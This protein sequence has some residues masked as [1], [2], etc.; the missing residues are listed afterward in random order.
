MKQKE[1]L[2]YIG[3]YVATIIGVGLFVGFVT[4]FCCWATD[5]SIGGWLYCVTALFCVVS[6]YSL[7][8]CYAKKSWNMNSSLWIIAMLAFVFFGY[9]AIRR[10]GADGRFQGDY[11]L[12]QRAFDDDNGRYGLANKYATEILWCEYGEIYKVV[13]KKDGNEVFVGVEYFDD[14]YSIEFF[15]KNGN[16]LNGIGMNHQIPAKDNIELFIGAIIETYT[17]DSKLE[18]INSGLKKETTNTEAEKA[19]VPIDSLAE[20]AKHIDEYDDIGYFN[21]GLASAKKNNKYGLINKLGGI[22]VECQYDEIE[23]VGEGLL[24][25]KQNDKYS[26]ID[27]TGNFIVC[28]K[29]YHIGEFEHG[30]ARISYNRKYGLIDMSGNEIVE[31]KYYSIDSYNEGLFLVG[32]IHNGNENRGIL[33]GADAYG[34][35][36]TNGE[37]V[38]PPRFR[39]AYPFSEGYA[40][41]QNENYKY[42]YIDKNG[43]L[44]IDY[45]Y[46][47]AGDFHEGYAMVRE[48][49]NRGLIIDKSGRENHLSFDID[50]WQ[51]YFSCGL[52]W[53]DAYTIDRNDSQYG[54]EDIRNGHKCGYIDRQ[55][56]VIIPFVYSQAAAFSEGFAA[57]RKGFKRGSDNAGYID[58]QGRQITSFDYL[59]C[60][61]FKSGMAIVARGSLTSEGRTTYGYIDTSGTEVISTLDYEKVGFIHENMVC[62]KKNGKYGY[63]D[64]SGAEVIPFIYEDAHGFCDGLAQVKLNGKVGFIDKQGNSTFDKIEE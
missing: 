57:V 35:I 5:I 25:L 31:P 3:L 19:D 43:N 13:S 61:P 20:L 62:V 17:R 6:A 36:D 15:D 51:G 38:I 34:W 4:P 8:Q 52:A 42:G 16:Y 32:I 26:L 53:I 21:C 10:Y 37:E 18:G 22:V 48:S 39:H 30:Y 40:R 46:E 49:Y 47:D 29:D 23:R 50:S 14:Y 63:I 58:R 45:K 24:C 27:K 64:K 44:V 54:Y 9:I 60:E 2:T 59:G 1:V 12:I 33:S 56:N 11:I 55:G 28:N 41:V 7:W